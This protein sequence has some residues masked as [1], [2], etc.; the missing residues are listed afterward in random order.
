M[1]FEIVF[2]DPAGRDME[3]LDRRVAQRIARALNRLGETGHGDVVR[4][5]GSDD[6]LRLRVGDWRVRF[7][8]RVEIRP[9]PPPETGTIEV[10]VLEI[11]RVLPRGRAYR[12]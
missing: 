8:R 2:T 1:I 11:L 6:E 9:A 10:L 12:H 5:V 3:R 4:L 7:L